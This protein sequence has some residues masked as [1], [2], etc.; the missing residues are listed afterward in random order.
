MCISK[1]AEVSPM[2][3]LAYPRHCTTNAR[4]IRVHKTALNNQPVA[5]QSRELKPHTNAGQLHAH[6]AAEGNTPASQHRCCLYV[7][8][9]CLY[10]ASHAPAT[11][12]SSPI[13]P[14]AWLGHA[15]SGDTSTTA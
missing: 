15:K 7:K 14:E 12:S 2:S 6:R 4:Q 10:I 11:N 9:D 5:F 1:P 13:M 3:A 8:R